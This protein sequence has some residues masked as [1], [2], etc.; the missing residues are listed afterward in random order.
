MH[1]HH[2]VICTR[3]LPF[4][5]EDDRL[6]RHAGSVPKEDTGL[7]WKRIQRECAVCTESI[8]PHGCHQALCPPPVYLIIGD[9][10][11]I[12]PGKV[13]HSNCGRSKRHC[14]VTDDIWE[15]QGRYTERWPW[16]SLLDA[17]YFDMLSPRPQTGCCLSQPA[18]PPALLLAAVWRRGCAS[19]ILPSHLS[20]LLDGQY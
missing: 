2:T 13:T 10:D 16:Y 8:H 15:D 9:R 7:N 18:T 12:T 20:V 11:H 14:M 17:P 4:E 19:V 3:L 5:R 6:S 1:L